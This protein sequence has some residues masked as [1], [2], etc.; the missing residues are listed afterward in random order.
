MKSKIINKRTE[1]YKK[2]I[3]KL[4]KHFKKTIEP[5]YLLEKIPFQDIYQKNP[6]KYF[7]DPPYLVNACFDDERGDP[8]EQC[9]FEDIIQSSSNKR[10]QYAILIV[11]ENRNNPNNLIVKTLTFST[12]SNQFC[13]NQERTFK[14]VT[15]VSDYLV[16]NFGFK[17]IPL[18]EFPVLSAEESDPESQE[19][20]DYEVYTQYTKVYEDI[21][22]VE[23]A[24]SSSSL[25]E[26]IT[27]KYF[28]EKNLNCTTNI[29][30]NTPKKRK[31][32][33]IP[34]N[35]KKS[36]LFAVEISDSEEKTISENNQTQIVPESES[37]SEQ[38][39]EASKDKKENPLET[40][41]SKIFDSKT[42]EWLH[43]S[44]F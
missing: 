10:K 37:E 32:S 23:K 3:C 44:V 21:K 25:R 6:K 9:Y 11:L 1:E 5:R 16:I 31:L 26:R 30:P 8:I 35:I 36:K 43:K 15:I 22:P 13:V 24:K 18:I 28:N 4:W 2:E 29:Q 38:E 42:D 17:Y 39:E 34:K 12:G 19:E 27:S 41:D 20:V 14:T 40:V 7:P 33:E